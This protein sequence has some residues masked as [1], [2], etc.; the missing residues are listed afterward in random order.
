LFVTTDDIACLEAC[1]NKFSD[2]NLISFSKLPQNSDRPIHRLTELDDAYQRNK[3]AILD[4]LM[5]ALSHKFIF[6]ELKENR[7]GAKYS[8]FS[9]LAVDLRNSKTVLR[10]VISRPE[11]N[12]G[13]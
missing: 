8:G 11:L 6:F 9:M 4:L 5:L 7:W 13:W 2:I 12:I 3:D 10:E 1:R